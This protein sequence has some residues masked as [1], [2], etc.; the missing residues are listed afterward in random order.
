MNADR[1][2][3]FLIALLAALT[4]VLFLLSLTVGPAA[5]GFGDSMAALFSGKADG[6]ALIMREIR[7]P[8]AILGLMIGATLGLSGAVLQGYLR[9]PLAEPGLLGISASASLGAVLAIYTGLSAAFLLALPLA[10]LAG[11]VAAVLI[12]QALAGARG[13]ALIVIL[14]GI[15]VTSFAGAMTS[16]ALNL[17]PNPFAALEIMFWML[18]SLTDRSMTHMWLSAPFMLIGWIMLGSLGRA[19]DALTLGSETAASMGIELRRVQLLAVF[20][21][22]ASV[23]AATAVA[24]AIGFVGLVVPHI[25]RP[26]VGARPSRLLPASALGGASMV[27]GADIL[28]RIIAPERDLKL[29]VLTAIVGAPFFLWLVFRTRRSLT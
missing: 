4:L 14:A 28:V 20:G 18:G 21:T 3:H 26:L 15:A 19:L 1:R 5:I 2:Y 7:L 27:L 8:R 10:A 6:V 16:L 25:L 24:G 11:A 12:V 23:G 17:S 13:S 9:N 29:G 22:A